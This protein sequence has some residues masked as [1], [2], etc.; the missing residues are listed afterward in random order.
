MFPLSFLS[1]S[2]SSAIDI[3]VR[4]TGFAKAAF[5]AFGW[6]I[7]HWFMLFEF[8]ACAWFRV[9]SFDV[10]GCCWVRRL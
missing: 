9:A 1:V 6:Y 10:A 2:L 7:K 3:G 4:L 5:V 8:T